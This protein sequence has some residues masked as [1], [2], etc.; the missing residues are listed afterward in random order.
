MQGKDGNSRQW[1]TALDGEHEDVVTWETEPFTR[2]ELAALVRCLWE[3]ARIGQ[4]PRTAITRAWLPRLRQQALWC[5]TGLLADQQRLPDDPNAWRRLRRMVNRG[6]L[7]MAKLGTEIRLAREMQRGQRDGRP[8]EFQQAMA[9]E[10]RL[11]A[12][13]YGAGSLGLND[14]LEILRGE[15]L[16][17][18]YE[19]A[20]NDPIGLLDFHGGHQDNWPLSNYANFL[21]AVYEDITGSRPGAGTTFSPTGSAK[22]GKPSS[23]AVR[24]FAAAMAFVPDMSHWRAW[25][26]VRQLRHKSGG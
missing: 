12:I 10:A 17:R 23:P 8:D 1:L 3:L 9:L 24:F 26:L 21:A 4:K 2:N 22:S 15:D 6:R 19:V 16:R 11:E 20:L 25:Y 13:Q 5:Q 18:A 14:D 7:D